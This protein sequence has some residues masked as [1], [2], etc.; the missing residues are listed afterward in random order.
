MRDFGSCTPTFI[1]TTG[2]HVAARLAMSRADTLAT[3]RRRV[4]AVR[5]FLESAAGLNQA[6]SVFVRHALVHSQGSPGTSDLAA[7]TN[8]LVGALADFAEQ[9]D[10]VATDSD[11]SAARSKPPELRDT[12]QSAPAPG[13]PWTANRT[14]DSP[15]VTRIR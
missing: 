12:L 15:V 14:F 7:D 5:A 13:Q 4:Q 9:L 1:N 2:L 11:D 10:R 8:A 3:E 6:L